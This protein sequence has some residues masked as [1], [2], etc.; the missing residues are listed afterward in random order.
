M[1]VRPAQAAAVSTYAARWKQAKLFTV[2]VAEAMPAAAYTF[3]PTPE[4][5]A[6]GP[7]MSHLGVANVRYLAR[8]KNVPPPMDEPPETADKATV[9]KFLG[10]SFDWCISQIESFSEG[11]LDKMVPARGKAPSVSVRDLILSGFIHT[12]HHRGY[13]EVYLRLKGVTPPGYD[14]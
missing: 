5:R 8:A 2:T 11:D 10:A 3:K 12:A 4:M 1:A 6:F 7:L 13:S 9:L 14:V